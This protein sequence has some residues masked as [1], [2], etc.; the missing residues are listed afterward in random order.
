MGLITRLR[1]RGYGESRPQV[2][3][4]RFDLCAR[5]CASLRGWPKTYGRHFRYLAFESIPKKSQNID[6]S[7]L[8][9]QRCLCNRPLPNYL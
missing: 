6:Q 7:Y 1:L 9:A 3:I 4:G 5:P 8:H 2:F